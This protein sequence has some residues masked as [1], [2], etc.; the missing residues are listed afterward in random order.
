MCPPA[1]TLYLHYSQKHHSC[2]R[3]GSTC[4]HCV[5][6]LAALQ[7]TNFDGWQTA[8]CRLQTGVASDA[9]CK[10]LY[11]LSFC[12]CVNCSVSEQDI[13]NGMWAVGPLYFSR[14]WEAGVKGIRCDRGKRGKGRI[15]VCV[16]VCVCSFWPRSFWLPSAFSSPSLHVCAPPPPTLLYSYR[17]SVAVMWLHYHMCLK[18]GWCEPM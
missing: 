10:Y 7:S 8:D 2:F 17:T 15:C 13:T 4:C 3:I 6:G 18:C 11:T 5:A 9:R 12:L 14:N 16:F 1:A